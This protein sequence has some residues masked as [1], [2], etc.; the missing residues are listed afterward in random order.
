MG[1]R[2]H[3]GMPRHHLHLLR[4]LALAVVVSGAGCAHHEPVLTL[5]SLEVGNPTFA[6]TLSA[7]AGTAVVSGNRVEILLNGDEIF[8]AKLRIIKAARK[9]INY[10]QYVFEEGDPSR[11]IANALAERCRAGVTVNLLVDAVG[12]LS[13]P[14]EYRQ[15][16]Q[17]AGCRIE[18]FRPLSPLE[19]DKVNNRNHRRILVVDGKVAITGGSG[20][21]GK[22]GGN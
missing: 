4:A 11:D 5:P 6:S 8:P 7:Y 1:R 20:T 13:M 10:A 16:M 22:W 12:A 15:V 14:D 17:Q 9:T 2:G 18:T 19:V 3:R 21:S